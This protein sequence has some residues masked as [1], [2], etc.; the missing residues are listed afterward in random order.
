MYT[1]SKD[2]IFIVARTLLMQ[3]AIFIALIA[4][5]W[6]FQKLY[7]LTDQTV[8]PECYQ[9]SYSPEMTEEEKGVQLLDALVNRM[10]YELD[11]TYGWSANDIIFNKWVMDNRAYRQFGTY[12]AT[13]MLLDNYSTVIAKLGSSD[14]EN[15]NLYKARL[16]QFAFAPQRWGI[17]FIPS[18]EQAYKKGLNSIKKYQTDLLNKKAVYNARTDD[19]YEAFNVILGETVFGY[20]LGLLQ[21]SQNLS[22]YELD[23]KIYEVQGVILVVRDYLNALYTL[24]PEI[25]AKGNAENF[26][27]AMSLLD[28]IC[29]YD[30][31]YITSTVNSGELIVSYL[32]FARNRISDIRDS[33]RI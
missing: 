13:K 24:Y 1:P 27:Q 19:I 4:S 12:V 31:L 11:S 26:A 20:A 29:T 7:A 14:R 17:F 25:A 28:K 30:P 5:M 32:L 8:F 33:I 21:N 23:N 3:V 22:F 6:G 10:R 15:E 9:V 2:H 16:N 18:A